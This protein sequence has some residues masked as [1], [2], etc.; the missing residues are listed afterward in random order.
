M[1]LHIKNRKKF[2]PR[3]NCRSPQED[4]LQRLTDW[5]AWRKD[6]LGLPTLCGISYRLRS[7]ISLAICAQDTV[8]L[9]GHLINNFKSDREYF[10][11]LY[12]WKVLLR[13]FFLTLTGRVNRC[14]F[15]FFL[16]LFLNLKHCISFAKHQNESATGIHMLRILNPPPSSL[17]TP[18]LWVVPVY[19]PQASSIVH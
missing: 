16:I 1:S 4:T 5:A 15:F 2:A 10:K 19:Q 18:S 6:T 7:R 17:P 9:F 8:C 14:F 11:T 3:V 12:E 13:I